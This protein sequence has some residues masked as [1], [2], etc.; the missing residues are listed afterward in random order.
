MH[1]FVQQI[2]KIKKLKYAKDQCILNVIIQIANKEFEVQ[3]SFTDINEIFCSFHN[4]N[5]INYQA[6]CIRSLTDMNL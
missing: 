2:I 3:C 1:F 5:K 4:K 6:T